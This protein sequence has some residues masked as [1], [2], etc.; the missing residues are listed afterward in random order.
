MSSLFLLVLHGI[1]DKLGSLSAAGNAQQ[2]E[3]ATVHARAMATRSENCSP[4]WATGA[5]ASPT[6]QGGV[7]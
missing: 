2:L 7:R 6:Y 4:P 3:A 1:L 5:P